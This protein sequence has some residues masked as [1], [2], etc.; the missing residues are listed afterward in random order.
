MVSEG[1][2]TG[3]IRA[4]LAAMLE[5]PLDEIGATMTFAQL[6]IDSG[7]ITNL[8]L[9]LEEH[10]DIEVDPDTAVEQPTIAALSAY[11]VGLAGARKQ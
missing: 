3:W 5:R 2:V 4:E 11:A 7:L 8:L 1:D 10:L 9:A 6:G